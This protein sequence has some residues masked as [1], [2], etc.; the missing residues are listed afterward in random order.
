[1]HTVV[2]YEIK[3]CYK[4]VLLQLP[5]L[6]P[7][8]CWDDDKHQIGVVHD[9]PFLITYTDKNNAYRNPQL[10][11]LQSKHLQSQAWKANAQS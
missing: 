5:R 11:V 9:M 6:L 1:M 10:L 8:S 2:C 3:L 4:K 7:T